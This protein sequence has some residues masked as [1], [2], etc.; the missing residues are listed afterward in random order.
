M[1]GEPDCTCP[2]HQGA[3]T[4]CAARAEVHAKACCDVPEIA[5]DS[6]VMCPYCKGLTDR[7]S[8]HV[9]DC[10]GNRHLML[11]GRRKLSAT[12]AAAH[13]ARR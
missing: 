2:C 1:S 5:H 9:L 4:G 11:D 10:T 6:T 8:T 7:L 3:V 12:I 13:A